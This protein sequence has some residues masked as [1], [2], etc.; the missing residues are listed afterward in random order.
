MLSPLMRWPRRLPLLPG[1]SS[2]LL[3]LSL[4]V[5]RVWVS[6]EENKMWWRRFKASF[7]DRGHLR[8]YILALV[9]GVLAAVCVG[10][11]FLAVLL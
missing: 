11:V 2:F 1:P 5:C 8:D 4:P 9:A 7:N 10:A 6:R 3:T